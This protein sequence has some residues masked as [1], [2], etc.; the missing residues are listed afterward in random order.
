VVISLKIGCVTEYMSNPFRPQAQST[1]KRRLPYR[2]R[3]LHTSGGGN[4]AKW[5]ESATTKEG[6]EALSL[7]TMCNYTALKYP[8][9]HEGSLPDRT[10]TTAKSFSRVERKF[11][12]ANRH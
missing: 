10:A 11:K 1:A 7:T 4:K 12:A 3:L 5:T 2:R 6:R 9:A 8:S